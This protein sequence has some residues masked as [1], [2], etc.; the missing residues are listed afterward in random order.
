M[1][2]C[3]FL[4]PIIRDSDKSPHQP[5]AWRALQDMVRREFIEGHSGP[6]SVSMVM[7]YKDVKLTPGE[8]LDTEQDKPVP[9]VSRRYTI[10]IAEARLDDLRAILRKAANTFDQK[11]IYLSVAGHAELVEATPGDGFL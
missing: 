3:S 4:I 2:E 11:C 7:F 1:L 9:D 10:A 5:L 6:E 8:Y